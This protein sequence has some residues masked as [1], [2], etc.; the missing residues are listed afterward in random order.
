MQ[1]AMIEGVK[2]VGCTSIGN[3]LQQ[4]QTRL[5]KDGRKLFHRILQNKIPTAQ[6]QQIPVR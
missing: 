2:G 4:A 3:N 1:F 6:Q 5:F